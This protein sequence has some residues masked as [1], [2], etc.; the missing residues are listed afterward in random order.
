MRHCHGSFLLDGI[1]DGSQQCHDHFGRMRLHDDQLP[2]WRW[3]RPSGHDGLG[4]RLGAL[5]EPLLDQVTAP[6]NTDEDFGS[7]LFDRCRVLGHASMQPRSAVGG[8]GPRSRCPHQQQIGR[9]RGPRSSCPRSVGEHAPSDRN[10]DPVTGSRE[11]QRPRTMVSSAI[12]CSIG[13]SRHCGTTTASLTTAT[14]PNPGTC[15]RRSTSPVSGRPRRVSPTPRSRQAREPTPRRASRPPLPTA[16]PPCS[17][18]PRPS[19]V[20]RSSSGATARPPSTVGGSDRCP[21]RWSVV[22][23]ARWWS[24]RTSSRDLCTTVSSSV[25]TAPQPRSRRWCG[26]VTKPMTVGP[27]S[28]SSTPGTTP[29]RRSSAHPRLVI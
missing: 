6:I 27:R 5:A 16:R 13:P 21:T 28:S 23:R 17:F 26:H 4:H 1:G 24:S 15:R 20:M 10:L 29:T 9:M 19:A 12:V 7:A 25:S 8:Q 11:T 3:T 2:R 14:G 18:R 22:H